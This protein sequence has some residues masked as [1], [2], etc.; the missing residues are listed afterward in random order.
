LSDDTRSPSRVSGLDRVRGLCLVSMIVGHF[1]GGSVVSRVM[2][3]PLWVDGA[4]GFVLVSG[5]VLGIVRR[6]QIDRGGTIVDVGRASVRRAAELWAILVTV[7]VGTFALRAIID[8]GGTLPAAGQVGSLSS[9]A[10]DVS[11]LQ[12]SLRYI[13]ILAVY[14]WFLLAVPV[15]IAI[16]RRA[17]GTVDALL[18]SAAVY[19]FD[20]VAPID[21][22]RTS[23]VW[24]EDA[25]LQDAPLIA[26]PRWFSLFVI[27]MALGWNWTA[28][29]RVIMRPVVQ[30]TV[31]LATAAF[32][33]L[34]RAVGRGVF[35]DVPDWMVSKADLGPLTIM[36][37]VLLVA[38]L[39]LFVAPD[40]LAHRSSPL[41]EPGLRFLDAL[42]RSS[43]GSY[44]IHVF[45][46]FAFDF[47][48]G[49][50]FGT[51]FGVVAGSLAL[52]LGWGWATMQTHRAG[53][54]VAV[55][56]VRSSKPELTPSR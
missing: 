23:F 31:L 9:V 6:T 25:S 52:G 24:V 53:R 46:L 47:A 27:G 26:A 7:H 37:S 19:L 13:D 29:Q 54:S 3:V 28:V 36:Y 40:G 4:M 5:I 48:V 51:P 22:L 17:F 55:P 21:F 30:R 15:V 56:T 34:A 41:L 8:P 50:P 2:H 35:P 20:V 45:V 10:L 42:G 32:V 18:L 38:T 12:V 1:A 43:L 39:F 49:H 16:L 33:L 11:S 44:L 14:I